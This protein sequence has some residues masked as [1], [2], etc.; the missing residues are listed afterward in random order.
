MNYDILVTTGCGN[1][2]Q[3]GADIWSNHFLN[4]IY[5]IISKTKNYKVLV[6]SKRP[7]EWDSSYFDDLSIDIQ[8]FGDSIENTYKLLENCN[9]I[10]FLHPNYHKRNHLWEFR[11]KFET[12]FVHAYPRE[13]KNSLKDLPE[14]SRLQF[15][16]N[17][18]EIWYDEFLTYFKK[19]IW[20]GNN[21]TEFKYTHIIPNFYEFK[22]N[23]DLSSNI[24]NGKIGFTSR[25]ETR[26]CI[27]WMDNHKGYALTNIYDI[28]NLRENTEFK[29]QNIKIYQWKPEI[30]TKFM[31]K[32]WG[33]FH[34]AHFK[35]P[36][37]YSIFQAVDFGKLPIIHSD[38]GNGLDYKYKISSKKDFDIYI[39]T[40]L[41]DSHET[42]LHEWNK[43]RNYLKTFDNKSEWVNQIIQLF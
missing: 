8:F 2:I 3:G 17:V 33:I 7:T 36:F 13:M 1:T 15:G 29:L 14:L 41:T 27:H 21:P 22:H 42:R 30:L 28:H 6:D 26:K 35:E 31:L 12:I 23:L 19:V 38:W 5:P 39:H 11:D 37:G 9:K 20:I 43:L 16:T 32:D 10:H 24:D 25:A 40:I 4:E 34:G 18:D